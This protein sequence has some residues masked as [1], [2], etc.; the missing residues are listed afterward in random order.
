[1]IRRPPRSTRTD[2]L[3]PYTTLFRSAGYLE[4]LRQLGQTPDPRL[5]IDTARGMAAGAEAVA[6]VVEAAP[7]VD[8]LFCGGGLLAAGA[9]FECQKRGWSMPGRTSLAS[10]RDI[11]MLHHLSPIVPTLPL[12]RP[13]MRLRSAHTP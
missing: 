12:P 5:I 2:T 10:L 4:A 7:D 6:H 13:Q 3:F 8:A 9:F 1:M 11:E